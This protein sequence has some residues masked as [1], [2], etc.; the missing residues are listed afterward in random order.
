M[1]QAARK[2]SAASVV[3]ERI[4]V[5]RWYVVAVL[6]EGAMFLGFRNSIQISIKPEITIKGDLERAGL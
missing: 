5:H 4:D 1:V 3:V 6:E 2:Q